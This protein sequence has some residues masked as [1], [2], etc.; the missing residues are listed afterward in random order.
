MRLV[1]VLL[2][3]S[4]CVAQSSLEKFNKT[5]FVTMQPAGEVRISA[6][7]PATATIRFRVNPG[8]H[9]NSN[10]PMSDLLIPTEV[11]FEKHAAV[12]VG[13]AAYPAGE[14]LALSFSPKQKLSVYQGDVAVTVPVS[15]AK[16]L[17]R[18]THKLKGSLSYQACNDNACVPPKKAPFEVTVVVE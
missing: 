6:K 15:A 14:E 16:P 3:A 12:T 10:Q 13:K 1:A 11:I 8:Y 4:A 17:K 18:G 9:V 2:L 7:K 5:N